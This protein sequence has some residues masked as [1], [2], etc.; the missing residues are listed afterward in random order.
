MVN[1]PGAFSNFF[2]RK[3]DSG[4]ELPG[5]IFTGRNLRV[6]DGTSETTAYHL[7]GGQ[8]GREGTREGE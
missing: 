2:W 5:F 8:G 3:E 6:K 4:G 7:G 1:Y